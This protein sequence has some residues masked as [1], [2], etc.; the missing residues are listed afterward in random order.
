MQRRKFIQSSTVL[1]AGLSLSSLEHLMAAPVLRSEAQSGYGLKLLATNWGFSGTMDQFCEK[2][3]T[4]GY[5]GIEVW[6]PLTTARQNELFAALK[7]YNLE[8]GFLCGGS[9]SDWK[10]H[11]TTFQQ[12]IDAAAK[13]VQQRPLYINCHSG[14]DYFTAEQ[15]Q[16][17][18]DHT[19]ALAAETGIRICHETHRGRMLYSAPI[20]LGFIQRNPTLLLTLDISHWCTVH[21]SLLAD[22]EE[23]VQAAL[24]RTGHIHAR[25]GHPEGPQ[26]TDPQAQ[27]WESAVKAHLNWWD[28]VVERKRKKGEWMTM[29]TE[30]GPPDYMWTL[31][32]TRQPLAD[33]WAVN[34]KMQKLLRQ[35][36]S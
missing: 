22:Q 4:E 33:Q 11:L 21:E 32:Y 7:K 30:F 35:R 17:F 16:R 14:R 36:Y 5:D 15:N 34:V 24:D 9:E 25:I 12:A 31:P 28:V 6:W 20:T 26:I 27:E 18:I 13:N 2:V 3:K 23:T 29:L 10:P 8:V 1:S 19:S